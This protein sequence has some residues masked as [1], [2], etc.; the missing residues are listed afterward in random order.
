MEKTPGADN[1]NT[2]ERPIEPEQ[3][4]NGRDE[5]AKK[6]WQFWVR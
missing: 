5:K 4:V 6:S 2:R 3:D 1:A